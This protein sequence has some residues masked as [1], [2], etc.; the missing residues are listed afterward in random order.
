MTKAKKEDAGLVSVQLTC[1]Y[2]GKGESWS[3]G[4]VIE[5]DAEEAERLISLGAAKATA[6]PVEPEEG[7]GA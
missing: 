1:I 3:A 6:K 4:S 7:D 5:V 2:S